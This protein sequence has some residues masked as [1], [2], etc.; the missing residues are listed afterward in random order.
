MKYRVQ[1]NLGTHV[2]HVTLDAPSEEA[3]LAKA[4][5]L[6]AGFMKR[7]ANGILTRDAPISRS[8]LECLSE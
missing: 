2:M 7:G 4:K 3:A 6:R 8:A 5:T 1:V